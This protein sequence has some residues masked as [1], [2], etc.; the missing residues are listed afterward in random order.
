MFFGFGAG[1]G[2]ILN[3]QDEISVPAPRFPPRSHPE[4]GQ[5]M[6]VTHPVQSDIRPH[7][8]HSTAT[9]VARS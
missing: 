6:T 7:A 5:T 9:T 3:A 8:A 2:R 1:F 4:E